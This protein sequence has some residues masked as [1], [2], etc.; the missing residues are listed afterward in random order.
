MLLYWFLPGDID[1][2]R[3]TLFRYIWAVSDN[4]N[5]AVSTLT[6]IM[7][8]VMTGW[9]AIAEATASRKQQI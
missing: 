7:I 4:G 1:I 9:M 3:H 8:R 5:A 2:K 6:A